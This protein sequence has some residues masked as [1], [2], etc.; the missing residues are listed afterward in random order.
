LPGLAIAPWLML[1]EIGNVVFWFYVS[2]IAHWLRKQRLSLLLALGALST[3]IVCTYLKYLLCI[4]RPPQENWLITVD[5]PYGFPSSHSAVA[6]FAAVFLTLSKKQF[7]PLLFLAMLVAYSRVALG[8]HSPFDIV[9]GAFLGVA[10]ALIASI[11]MRSQ[12]ALRRG[13]GYSLYALGIFSAFLLY[14]TFPTRPGL[15]SGGLIGLLF[16]SK[17][18]YAGLN[19]DCFRKPAIALSLIV[20]SLLLWTYAT[21]SLTRDRAL[22]FF[23]FTS[24]PTA[25]HP[26]LHR[27]LTRLFKKRGKNS[28]EVAIPNW[29]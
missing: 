16:S 5:S 10:V 14:L 8:V 25:I 21:L 15:A 18:G 24:Y 26:R 20:A 27:M 2:F 17:Y 3:Y 9:G 28:G 13:K 29:A 7:F 12:G 1:T 23:A 19:E 11:A 22:A 6:F 4:P